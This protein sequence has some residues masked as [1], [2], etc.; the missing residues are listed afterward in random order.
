MPGECSISGAANHLQASGHV[1]AGN[2]RRQPP[3]KHWPRVQRA[4]GLPAC[5]RQTMACCIKAAACP[6]LCCRFDEETYQAQA[7]SNNTWAAPGA[8]TG[9]CMARQGTAWH[10]YW[11]CKHNPGPLYCM[12]CVQAHCTAPGPTSGCPSA[13]PPFLT[14]SRAMK[15]SPAPRMPRLRWRSQSESGH[16]WAAMP[17]PVQLV[18]H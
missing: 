5:L 14:H 10:V 17:C 18:H 12:Y 1:V 2:W 6:G 13:T 16:Y 11:C 8:I 9:G 7:S 4:D 15:H 3:P